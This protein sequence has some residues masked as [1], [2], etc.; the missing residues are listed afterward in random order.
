VVKVVDVPDGL[1]FTLPIN[2]SC[3][4]LKQWFSTFF[5]PRPITATHYITQRALSET[6]M[7][8]MKCS[9]VNKITTRDPLQKWFT[10][11]LR[12]R[13]PG[14]K[15]TELKLPRLL[16][17][18]RQVLQCAVVHLEFTLQLESSFVRDVVPEAKMRYC[19]HEPLAC[20]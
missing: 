13:P 12:S 2:Q 15:T 10:T 1:F 4:E 8:Q 17:L 19:P 9:C 11:L 7:K 18:L 3:H 16:S 20:F 14:L 6:P 5:V